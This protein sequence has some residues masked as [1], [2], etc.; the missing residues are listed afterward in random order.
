MATSPT[1]APYAHFSSGLNLPNE[2]NS[3]A[4]P[5]F[6]PLTTAALGELKGRLNLKYSCCHPTILTFWIELTKETNCT[7]NGFQVIL[8][9]AY[10]WSETTPR[11]HLRMESPPCGDAPCS[12]SSARPLCRMEVQR[13]IGKLREVTG[14]KNKCRDRPSFTEA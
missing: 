1:Q 5:P 9:R 2:A 10:P 8:A 4:W 11:P 3:L 13:N 7:C 6:L 14:I 12:P